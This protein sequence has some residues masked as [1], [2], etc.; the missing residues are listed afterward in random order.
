M[1]PLPFRAVSAC[2]RM[3]SPSP[4]KVRVLMFN[5]GQE[6]T[7]RLR[8]WRTKSSSPSVTCETALHLA[9]HVLSCSAP[10]P[11]NSHGAPSSSLRHGGCW[12]PS[13]AGLIDHDGGA[14]DGPTRRPAVPAQIPLANLQPCHDSGPAWPTPHRPGRKSQT[15][16]H[17]R[18]AVPPTAPLCRETVGVKSH[19]RE[20][21][22]EARWGGRDTF[23]GFCCFCFP[24]LPSSWLRDFRNH[25]GD[26]S[27]SILMKCNLFSKCNLFNI[28]FTLSDIQL[29]LG[30]PVPG[31]VVG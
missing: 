29:K 7:S 3:L 15:G 26:H 6:L 13:W 30:Q 8:Q 28:F 16:S 14:L 5:P 11:I 4:C 17:G 19:Q 2:P 18:V 21:F 10:C 24:F 22:L 23:E 9:T 27:L 12:R 25:H 31:T 1:Q 20:I